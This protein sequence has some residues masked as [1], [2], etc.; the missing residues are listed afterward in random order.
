MKGYIHSIETLGAVDGP[1]VR[2]VVFFQGCPMRCLYCHNPDT[3]EMNVGTLTDTDELIEKVTRNISFY[4][5][6]G[7]TATG[8]E[9]LMQIDFLT[10]LFSKAKANNIHTCI[11]TSGITFNP[12][13]TGKFDKLIEV[14]DLV[15]LDIKHIDENEHIKLTKQSGK[16]VLEFA[17]Y[18]NSKNKKMWI[19]H[20]IVPGI[21]LN[22]EYLKQL[23]EF[24]NPIRDNIEKIE[25]LP[26]HSLGKHKYDNMGLDYPL[27]GTLDGTKEQGEHAKQLIMEYMGA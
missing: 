27:S 12:D 4:R 17:K 20:V 15:M 13:D 24:L 16:N 23:G 22:D 5:T 25:T 21:T 3:W 11:D 19:R 2:F 18:L 8:G 14:T 10:E 9:P 1:G 7:I 26:Y 6:G